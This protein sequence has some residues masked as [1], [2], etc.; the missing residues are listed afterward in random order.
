MSVFEDETSKEVIMLK[1]GIRP[2]SIWYDWCPIRRGILD[3]WEH[4]ECIRKTLCGPRA[5]VAIQ[6]QTER[7]QRKPDQLTPWSWTLASRTTKNKILLFKP[8]HLC[9]F[10]MAVLGSQ[11]FIQWKGLLRGRGPWSNLSIHLKDLKTGRLSWIIWCALN[12]ITHVSIKGKQSDMP[13]KGAEGDIEV[14][15]EIGV[16]W[17]Q[18]KECQQLEETAADSPSSL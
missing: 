18:A 14:E 12:A 16:M 7:P 11:H 8:P 3:A 15:R 13:T 5:K 17:P 4:Q 9:Y 2:G 6:S 10:C 1:W